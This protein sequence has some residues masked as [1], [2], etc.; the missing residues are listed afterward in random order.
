VLAE[1]WRLL[2]FFAGVFDTHQPSESAVVVMTRGEISFE[3]WYG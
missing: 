3:G 1:N 2:I